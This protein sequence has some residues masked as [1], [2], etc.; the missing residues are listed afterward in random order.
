MKVYKSKLKN[1][2]TIRHL[3]IFLISLIVT[4]LLTGCFNSRNT[5]NGITFV[6][7]RGSRP[8]VQSIVWSPSDKDKIL[9]T[10]FETPQEPAEVYILDIKT[11]QKDILAKQLP[12]YFFEAKWTPD[13]KHALI[14]AENNTKGF[15]PSGWWMVNIS[16]KSS[17]YLTIPNDDAAWSPDG[18]TIAVL[19][20]EE[21]DAHDII[22]IDL[23]LINMG[24]K[25]EETI[26]TYEEADSSSGLSWS[27]D[28]QYL[29]FSLGKYGIHS[30]YILNMKTR[31]VAKI[32]ENIGS[33][34]PVWSPEGN[35]IA[36]ER[37]PSI[38]LIDM[39]GKCEIEIPNLENAWSLTWSPD[40]K[41]LGYVG[42]DGIYF[43]EIDKVL[44]RNIYQN[45]CE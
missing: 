45:L 3:F 44:G 5:N 30:L 14:L 2:T 6:T 38:H 1:T 7:S 36:F 27:S 34:K 13:G 37:Y 39:D 35:I 10:A 15:E 9:V 33:E 18:K 41:K 21:N 31:Q 43:L 26:A 16:T 25:V 42:K 28:G 20:Q 22:K 12:G 23:Q 32:T 24:T 19:H 4:N 29:V 11:G 8:P 40:G 17:E